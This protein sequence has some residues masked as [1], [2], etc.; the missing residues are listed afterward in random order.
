VVSAPTINPDAAKSGNVQISGDFTNDS[1]SLLAEQLKYGS[2]PVAFNVET[3]DVVSA[4]LGL[5][6]LTA[7]LLAGGIGLGLVVLYCLAYY[8]FL[9]F[10]VI[11][12]LAV[13][14]VL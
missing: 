10:V 13:S 2:L 8:R 7:G 5:E 6:Q 1:A 14:T 9:G 3:I 4:T 12:S 11:A